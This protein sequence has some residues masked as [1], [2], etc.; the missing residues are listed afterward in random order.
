[1]SLNRCKDQIF[2]TWNGSSDELRGVLA[3]IRKRYPNVQMEINIGSSV[4]YLNALVT[5]QNGKLYSR[6]YRDPSIQS[7]ALPYVTGHS[8]VAY[9]DWFRTALMRAVYY[10]SSIEDFQK[11]RTYLE[12]SC[13][14]NGYSLLFVETHVE[15]F[16][17]YFR[18]DSIRYSSDQAKY[19]AFRSRM[20]DYLANETVQ[21]DDLQK[22]NDQG[23]FIR[24]NYTYEYG[25]RV[26]FNAKFH[27]IWSDHFGEHSVLSGRLAKMVLS[28][29]HYRSLND[30]LVRHKFFD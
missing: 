24:F 18:V 22:I 21:I 11:E 27:E 15:H 7:Y 13:L 30:L 19:H 28:T 14:A 12:M 4:H 9:S 8:K 1:L 23:Q 5:N 3:T 10:C 2:L 20:F 26:E 29:E 16:F 25:S 6:V 17:Q